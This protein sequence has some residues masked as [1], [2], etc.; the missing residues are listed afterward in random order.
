[1][2]EGKDCSCNK[3]NGSTTDKIVAYGRLSVHTKYLVKSH[4]VAN[5]LFIK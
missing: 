1:M 4:K 2:G 3:N 5:K